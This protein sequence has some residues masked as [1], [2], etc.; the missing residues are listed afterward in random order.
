MQG[1]QLLFAEMWKAGAGGTREEA[2][3]RASLANDASWQSISDI[4]YHS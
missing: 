4:F 1:M 2:M 3:V